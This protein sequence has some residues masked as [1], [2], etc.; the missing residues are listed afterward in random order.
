[1]N[2]DLLQSLVESVG[3]MSALIFSVIQNR[4]TLKEVR[5]QAHSD[6][7]D[8]IYQIRTLMIT[9]PDLHKVW[10]GG[11]EGNAIKEIGCH[12]QF[13]LV[14]MLLHMNE[15]LYLRMLD[16]KIKVENNNELGP[17]R[18]NLKTDLS[19]PNFQKVWTENRIVRESYDD[20]FQIEVN[21]I[22]DEINC[23]NLKDNDSLATKLKMVA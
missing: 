8:K 5:H 13:Y 18:E 14:K 23:G 15:S 19:A 17:W 12:K 2:Y 16:S 20:K 9:D 6:T 21:K 22:I 4:E 1:M 11:L 7:I 10:D 3:I